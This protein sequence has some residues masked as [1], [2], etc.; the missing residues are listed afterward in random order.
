MEK[1]EQLDLI[2]SY[3]QY[4]ENSWKTKTR[5]AR[6]WFSNLIMINV[7]G[8]VP[9]EM[10]KAGETVIDPFKESQNLVFF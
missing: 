5:V 2:F 6:S 8:F 3:R 10:R 7:S 4:T 9:V 1:T